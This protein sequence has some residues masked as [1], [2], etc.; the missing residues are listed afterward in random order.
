MARMSDDLANALRIL[1]A[2]Q[3]EYKNLE[4]PS[5]S[6]L[7][8][9]SSTVQ[10]NGVY[11]KKLSFIAG[12]FIF[13]G[14]TEKDIYC[15]EHDKKD[16]FSSELTLKQVL[17]YI[18]SVYDWNHLQWAKCNVSEL[19][20]ADTFEE[21]AASIMKHLLEVVPLPEGRRIIVPSAP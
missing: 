10:E 12:K 18:Y 6:V 8:H 2:L 16:E 9:A 14:V 19:S 15:S 20:E 13:K 7:L 21:R 4:L 17:E 11:R 5:D 3:N 1:V